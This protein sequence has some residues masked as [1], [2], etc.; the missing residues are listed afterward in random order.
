MSFSP[1]MRR[2]NRGLLRPVM[3]D[4]N[5][6]GTP[7]D[8]TYS[9]TDAVTQNPTEYGTRSEGATH[10]KGPY[11]TPGFWSGPNR[12][13][14]SQ[15]IDPN[16]GGVA[17]DTSQLGWSKGLSPFTQFRQ[18]FTGTVLTPPRPNML[19]VGRVGRLGQRDTLG[20]RAA[21]SA[22]DYQPSQAQVVNAMVNPQLGW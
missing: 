14:P 10:Q 5:V 8:P 16:T 4:E 13:N 1:T 11:Q 7:G 12:V 22:T 19:I 6:G 18:P 15:Y 2:R 17:N 3:V 21:A 20:A 9:P